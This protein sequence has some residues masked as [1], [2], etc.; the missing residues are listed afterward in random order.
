MRSLKITA[1]LTALILLTSACGFKDFADP[2]PTPTLSPGGGPG[3]EQVWRNSDLEANPFG[4]K[5]AGNIVVADTEDG[6]NQTAFIDGTTGKVT[7]RAK[8][9][10]AYLDLDVRAATDKEGRPLVA[11][12]TD[13]IDAPATKEKVYDEQG[14]LV[15]Q[16]TSSDASYAGGFV[17]ESDRL[18]GSHRLLI[19]TPSGRTLARLPLPR[20]YSPD[21]SGSAPRIQLVRKG[22]LVAGG[23]GH[24]EFGNRIALID[25]SRP[26]RARV[27]YLRPPSKSDPEANVSDVQVG[28][29]GR[30]Y[31][32]WAQIG[33]PTAP[34]ARYDTPG[35]RPAW[36]RSIPVNVESAPSIKPAI[37]VFPGP[38]SGPD[39]VVFTSSAGYALINPDTGRP[40]GPKKPPAGN[41]VFL[42]SGR[43]YVSAD[44]GLADPDA[45]TSVIDLHTGTVRKFDTL[46]AGATP[47]GYLIDA[48]E[49]SITAYRWN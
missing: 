29:S 10:L 18:G 22:L 1:P 13:N 28:G 34:L 43:A 3:L 6:S 9:G 12:D 35:T 42:T 38:N 2:H 11:F 39:T 25:V 4:L 46:L 48:N 33:A 36:S 24:G 27:R 44:P 37:K 7:G 5:I 26:N 41:F 32:S 31:V 45:K 23:I 15:W 14:H 17:A 19:Q 40:A 8:T 49:T 30:V 20:S 21:E 47:N 16:A